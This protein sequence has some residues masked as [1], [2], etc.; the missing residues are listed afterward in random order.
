M[1][2]E[3]HWGGIGQGRNGCLTPD[4]CFVALRT[5]AVLRVHQGQMLFGAS[6][7]FGGS[8]DERGT[9]L[10]KACDRSGSGNTAW[11]WLFQC[12]SRGLRPVGR[13]HRAPAVH[14]LVCFDLLRP[15]PG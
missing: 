6:R 5:I 10:R 7:L 13:N 8:T 4:N 2:E 3:M 15:Q 1:A 12:P 11:L 9:I 14:F